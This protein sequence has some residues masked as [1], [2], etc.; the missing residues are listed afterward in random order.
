LSEDVRKSVGSVKKTQF[1]KLKKGVRQ[2]I[3]QGFQ[4]LQR[5]RDALE[6]DED[7]VVF[8]MEQQDDQNKLDLIE[9]VTDPFLVNVGLPTLLQDVPAR[10]VLTAAVETG[11]SNPL[12]GETFTDTEPV[13]T[14]AARRGHHTMA[15]MTLGTGYDF[16]KPKF[17]QKAFEEI[18][19]EKPFAQ[20]IAFPCGPWS[21]L[22]EL[23]GRNRTRVLL[24]RMRRRKNRK[25]V[26]FSVDMAKEQYNAGRHFVIENPGPSRAWRE[27]PE[28]QELMALPGVQLVQL[29]QCRFNLRGPRGGLHR[30]RTWL[31]TSSEEVA[32]AFNKMT[33]DGSHDHEPVIGGK[34]VTEAA[35][36]Y[37]P[38]FSLTMVKALE[39]QFEADGNKIY[40]DVFEATV[41]TAEGTEG[42]EELPLE[43]FP[44]EDFD[45]VDDMPLPEAGEPTRAQRQAVQRLHFDYMSTLDTVHP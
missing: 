34:K 21:P 9:G 20:L 10:D 6:V 2:M 32:N 38:E 18:R 16:F 25:L 22:H 28:L 42:A 4:K 44:E 43:P 12:V 3:K 1:S 15:S 13:T 40:Q 24:L 36:H 35:G 26:K 5:M 11:G 37:T 39:R 41:L 8:I 45:E 30:K 27:C 7:N 31:L 23:Q 14:Q 29:D 33:C 19:R 17:R